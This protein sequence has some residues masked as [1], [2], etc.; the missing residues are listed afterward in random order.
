VIAPAI[1]TQDFMLGRTLEQ[2]LVVN[3]AGMGAVVI[4]GCGHPRVDRI[5]DRAELLLDAPV[6]GIVGGLHYPV[7]ASRWVVGRL[8]MQRIV[9]TG[10]WP[11]DPIGPDDVEQGIASITRRQP[12]LVAL[13]GHD[14]CDWSLDAFRTAFPSAHQDVRVGREILVQ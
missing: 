11:W 13:S 7:T 5:L 9:G 12:R 2:S 3:V 8:P 14:S 1:P 6:C 4:I 10:K